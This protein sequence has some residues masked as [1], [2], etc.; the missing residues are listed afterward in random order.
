MNGSLVL[1]MI[2]QAYNILDIK[3]TGL[4]QRAVSMTYATTVGNDDASDSVMIAPD[5]DHVNTSICP[6][7]SNKTYLK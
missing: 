5:A 3:V 7:V 4:T 1:Y 6:G 2:L